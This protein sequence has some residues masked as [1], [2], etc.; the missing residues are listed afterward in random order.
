MRRP[1]FMVFAA[2]VT[3]GTVLPAAGQESPKQVWPQPGR[4]E[5]S[6]GGSLTSYGDNNSSLRL[7]G[8]LGF[9]LSPRHEAGPT[10]NL[11]IWNSDLGKYA[12]GSIGVFYRYNIPTRSRHLIPFGGVRVVWP[13]GVVWLSGYDQEW[14]A[15]ARAEF[16]IR[17]LVGGRFS[18]DLTTFYRRTLGSLCEWSG[19]SEDEDRFGFAIG[20]SVFF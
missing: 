4:L 13:V 2:A 1:V 18:L 8:D 9:M 20:V 16:G 17:Y 11:Q 15:E 14:D 19:C 6:L 3:I 10:L 5:L 7:A 12:W